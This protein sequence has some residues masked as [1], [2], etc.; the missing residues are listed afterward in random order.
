MPIANTSRETRGTRTIPV[1]V[2]YSSS[3]VTNVR[4]RNVIMYIARLHSTCVAMLLREISIIS[5][6]VGASRTYTLQRHH[7]I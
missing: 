3:T 2:P 1:T 7:R 4:C 6:A 5:K